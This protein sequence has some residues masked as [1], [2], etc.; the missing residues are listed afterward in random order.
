MVGSYTDW[1]KFLIVAFTATKGDTMGCLFTV[2]V[3][4]TAVLGALIRF[5][6]PAGARHSWI[7]WVIL[8]LSLL[9]GFFSGWLGLGWEPAIAFGAVVGSALAG[10]ILRE[11]MVGL[12]NGIARFLQR[13]LPFLLGGVILVSIY[14]CCPELL[15]ALAVLGIVCLGL[16]VM[17]RLL[18]RK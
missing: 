6:V 3:I 16:W 18:W 5:D 1:V 7:S 12:G 8:T 14:Y 11:I 4:A 17:L 9:T 13:T 10:L 2:A 15:E